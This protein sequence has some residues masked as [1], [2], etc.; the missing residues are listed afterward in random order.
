MVDGVGGVGSVVEGV[1]VRV[2]GVGSVIVT[3]TWAGV[4]N[5]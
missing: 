3:I 2:I 5:I 1:G 4:S